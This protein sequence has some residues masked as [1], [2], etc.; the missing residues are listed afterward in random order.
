M[1]GGV[2][3]QS[4]EL[5]R[6]V[7]GASHHSIAVPGGLQTQLICCRAPQ[8]QPD[9]R[10]LRYQLA[11]LVHLPIRHLQHPADV[12]QHAARLQS[13]EGDDLCDAIAA[14]PLWT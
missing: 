2:A 13:A 1:G 11:K 8:R 12:A 9:W 14:I 6:D 4:S 3:V 7:K 5:L 10:V